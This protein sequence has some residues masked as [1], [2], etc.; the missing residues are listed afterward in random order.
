VVVLRVLP[1]RRRALYSVSVATLEP[2][3]DSLGGTGCGPG[4]GDADEVAGAATRGGAMPQ[5]SQ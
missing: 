2:I 1:A 4:A 5:T 3:C